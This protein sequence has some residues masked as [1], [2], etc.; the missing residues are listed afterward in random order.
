[1]T[2]R[3]NKY[4]LDLISEQL[5]SSD[6]LKKTLAMGLYLRFKQEDEEVEYSSA[7]IKE[8]PLFFENFVADV[9]ERVSGGRAWVLPPNGDYG[10]DFEYDTE[11]GKYLAQVKCQKD[12]LPFDPIALIHSNV[13]KRDAVGGYVITT[14]AFTSAA[15]RYADGLNV[16]LI[17]GVKL[18]ELWIEGLQEN[19]EEVIKAIPEWT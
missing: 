4:N 11:E 13:V 8:D 19:Q 10:V 14:G 17:D 5:C 6:E 3:K 12:D 15:K 2:K 7:F 1:M 16:E 9:F 18:V